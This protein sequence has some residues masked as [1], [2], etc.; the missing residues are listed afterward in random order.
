MADKAGRGP[1][2]PRY[3]SATTLGRTLVEATSRALS[4][5]DMG[6]LRETMKTNWLG[7]SSG[8]ER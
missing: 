5:R 4:G 3:L 1:A 7:P 8:A 2:A 6:D